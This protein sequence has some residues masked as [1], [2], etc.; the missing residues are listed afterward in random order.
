MRKPNFSSHSVI[1]RK[2]SVCRTSSSPKSNLLPPALIIK[3]LIQPPME[4]MWLDHFLNQFSSSLASSQTADSSHSTISLRVLHSPTCPILP[5]LITLSPAHQT[6]LTHS[7]SLT[8]SLT[9][10]AHSLS[11]SLAGCHSLSQ[12][13]ARPALGSPFSLL[14]CHILIRYVG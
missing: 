11:L 5:P 12:L 10:A 3:H 14:R 6:P 2:L 1:L 4:I 7:V 8:L 9:V 13:S